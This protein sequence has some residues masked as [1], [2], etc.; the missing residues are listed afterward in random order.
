MTE[1][2]L[3]CSKGSRTK[4]QGVVSK[5]LRSHKSLQNLPIHFEQFASS[6]P[7]ALHLG[8]PKLISQMPL[9]KKSCP[10]L[11]QMLRYRRN[12]VVDPD[13]VHHVLVMTE[14]NENYLVKQFLSY[15]CQRTL[16]LT[17]AIIYGG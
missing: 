11:I 9:G 8:M 14:N 6:K 3:I 5:S 7:L 2:L 1:L 16:L 12:T 4:Y 17:F 10:C 13:L 15:S